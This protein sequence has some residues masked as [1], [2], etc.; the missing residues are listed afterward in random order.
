MFLLPTGNLPKL[1]LRHPGCK[2]LQPPKHLSHSLRIHNIS[3]RFSDQRFHLE[4]TV[5]VQM[6]SQP[7]LDLLQHLVQEPLL[8]IPPRLDDFVH[9]PDALHFLG[10]NPLAHYQRLVCLA[11]AQSLDEC[12][13]GATFGDEAE[14]RERGKEESVRGCIDK[15]RERDEGGG[16]ADCGAVEGGDEDLGVRVEGLCYFEVVGHE[17][18]EPVA[19]EFGRGFVFWSGTGGGYVGAAGKVVLVFDRGKGCGV[20]SIRGEVSAFPC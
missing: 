5:A 11:D 1:F 7:L 3:L 6:V 16:E 2:S 12:A 4:Q 19:A 18:A 17:G 14:G 10:G 15:V 13:A 20:T 8:F 9:E